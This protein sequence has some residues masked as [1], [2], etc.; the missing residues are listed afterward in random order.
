MKSTFNTVNS[1]LGV[2]T[3]FTNS[4]VAKVEETMPKVIDEFA[5]RANQPGQFLNWVDLPKN[6]LERVDEIYSLSDKLKA[7]T[8]A[9]VLTVL[10]IGGSK[11]TVENMLGLNGLNINKDEILFYSDID[12]TSFERYLKRINK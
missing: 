5:K 6:Q 3:N 7:Q 8:G 1:G 11:H 12:L 4:N 9:K 10:G 2:V